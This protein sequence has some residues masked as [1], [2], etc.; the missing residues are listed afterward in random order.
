MSTFT[1]TTTPPF[2]ANPLQAFV[3]YKQARR[4]AK[5]GAIVAWFFAGLTALVSGP[6]FWTASKFGFQPFPA[7]L[8][9]AAFLT[10]ITAVLAVLG[11]RVWARP[12]P[13]KT[14]AVLALV[15]TDVI[16]VLLSFSLLALILVGVTLNF[17]I[18][19]FRGALAMKR[20][21]TRAAEIDVF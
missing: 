1:R 12:G 20:L 15:S 4:A 11:W 13:W 21:E 10:L 3:T 17:S 14:F 9:P 2:S 8:F 7:I 18:I 5:G 16:S 19:A 6:Y